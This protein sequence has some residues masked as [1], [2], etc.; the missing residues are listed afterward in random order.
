MNK[1]S[2]KN[3]VYGI[4]IGVA[5]YGAYYVYTRRRKTRLVKE[6]NWTFEVEELDNEN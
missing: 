1:M 4:L 3:V 5:A 2:I 6:G